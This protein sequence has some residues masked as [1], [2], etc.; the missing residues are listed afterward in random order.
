[1]REDSTFSGVGVQKKSVTNHVDEY[2]AL[3]PRA[4]SFTLFWFGAPPN[5]R[6]ADY[7]PVA[8]W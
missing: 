4:A 6:R 1:M 7:S 5:F 8:Q 2:I 3:T